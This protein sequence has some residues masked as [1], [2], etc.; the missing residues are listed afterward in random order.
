MYIGLHVTYPSF[1]SD[2]SDSFSKNTEILNFIKIRP[3]GVDLFHA[4]RLKWRSLKTES[5]E[6]KFDGNVADST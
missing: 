5:A 2:F 6:M 4:D 1:L 3:V